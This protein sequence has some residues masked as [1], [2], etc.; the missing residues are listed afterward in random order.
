M[1]AALYLCQ[2]SWFLPSSVVWGVGESKS[3]WGSKGSRV[4]LPLVPCIQPGYTAKL[5]VGRPSF[6]MKSLLGT[7]YVRGNSDL[8]NERGSH[9]SASLELT[10]RDLT[11]GSM[12][13]NP[14]KKSSLP[15]RLW[16][17]HPSSWRRNRP[18]LPKQP[19]SN[20]PTPNVAFSYI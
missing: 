10:H 5:R 7:E 15:Q 14:R 8:L 12:T 3:G 19:G 4:N 9:R 2:T 16:W 1:P 17:S 6:V 13:R 18:R 11:Y 20:R